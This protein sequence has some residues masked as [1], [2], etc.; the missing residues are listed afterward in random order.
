METINKHN[1]VLFCVLVATSFSLFTF[2][3]WRRKWQPTPLFLPGESQGRGSL[4]G[5]R[6]WGHTESDTTEV[7]QQQQQQ[8]VSSTSMYLSIYRHFILKIQPYIYSQSLLSTMPQSGLSYLSSILFAHLFRKH[9]LIYVL[10]FRSF[11]L[12]CSKVHLFAHFWAFAV[13]SLLHS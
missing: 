6:L 12:L 5:G 1:I 10:V 4:V 2:M 8:Y 9:S 7:T 3:H 11:G 13:T